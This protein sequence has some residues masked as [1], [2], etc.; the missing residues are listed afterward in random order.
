MTQH[1][2]SHSSSISVATGALASP[3]DTA[4]HGEY[5][6]AHLAEDPRP[7]LRFDGR[8]TAEGEF[9]PEPG[10]YHLYAGRF[11]PWA[12][13][14]VLV[15]DLAGLGEA[16]SLSYVD[17]AR[18]GRGWAFRGETGPD[19]VNGF[20]LLRQAYEATEPGF[21]GHVSVPT[22]WDRSTA[23]VVSNTYAH[24]DVDLSTA[25]ADVASP[26]AHDLYPQ[27][28]RTVV[29][30]LEE[31]LLPVVN[32]GAHV[33]LGESP[34]APAAREALHE[35]FDQLDVRLSTSRHL[36]GEQLTL[37]D[38]R[39]WVTAV[40]Y[41]VGAQ[42]TGARRLA[43]WPSLWRWARELLRL[44][45]F[46]RSTDFAAFGGEAVAEEWYAGPVD[47]VVD[48]NDERVAS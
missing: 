43:Q 39:L 45:A 12:Q 30:D 16:I 18:D 3:V 32:K 11:C 34:E 20:T 23:R 15:R 38:V 14:V 24:L 40:R 19:P 48:G 35:A 17:G 47:S 25:F 41:D 36:I 42:R 2:D 26:G 44:D 21:D 29:D 28:L 33:A 22:L 27:A 46:V 9:T 37:A 31:W 13:R 10:R 5:S 8:I 6:L 1:T 4:T 7:L